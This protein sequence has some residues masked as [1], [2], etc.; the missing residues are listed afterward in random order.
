MDPLKPVTDLIDATED[1]LGH[2]PHPAIV[3]VPIGAWVASNV[4]DLL[5]LLTGRRRYDDAARLS[6]AVGLVGAAGA[7]ATGLRDYGHIPTD[8]PSHA[9]ATQ[10]ALGNSVVGS[11]F[12]ASYVLRQRDHLSD[13]RPR[14]AARLLALAGGGLALYTAWLGGVLV[15]EYGEGVKPVLDRLSA[16]Q[17]EQEEEARGRQRLSPDSP[18]GL[19]GEARAASRPA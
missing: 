2:S 9:V 5:G 14:L 1:L 6:M 8:R 7:V 3:T 18:L 13:R 4:C 12:V 16:E 19:H 11:L 17:R 15:E 10:H